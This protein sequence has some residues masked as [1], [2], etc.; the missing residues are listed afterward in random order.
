MT[1]SDP[2][3]RANICARNAGPEHSG[4]TEQ[5]LNNAKRLLDAYREALT[6][7]VR[8][9]WLNEVDRSGRHIQESKA[10]SETHQG[11]AGS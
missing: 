8:S 4:L 7:T 6:D 10:P 11:E 9:L 1:E 2:E 3:R 5:E